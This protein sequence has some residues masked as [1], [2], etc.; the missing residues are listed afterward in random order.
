MLQWLPLL[1]ELCRDAQKYFMCKISKTINV[2]A[3]AISAL[4]FDRHQLTLS[5][6]LYG[7]LVSICSEQKRLLLF[8]AFSIG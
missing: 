2:G 8:Q 4:C 6:S 1:V 3:R 7:A 5:H